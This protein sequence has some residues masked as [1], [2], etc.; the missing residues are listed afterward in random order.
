MINDTSQSTVVTW[1][2]CG[3]TFDHHF[4]TNLLL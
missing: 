2:R 4:I 1:F 3:G